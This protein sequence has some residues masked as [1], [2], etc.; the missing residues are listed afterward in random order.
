MLLQQ[1]GGWWWWGGGIRGRSVHRRNNMRAQKHS[2]N[3][4]DGRRR[5]PRCEQREDGFLKSA[6]RRRKQEALRLHLLALY[7]KVTN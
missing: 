6:E 2:G 4:N 1:T 5:H 3:V 7:A